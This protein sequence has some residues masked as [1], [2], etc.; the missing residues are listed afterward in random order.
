MKHHR[1][2]KRNPK[3]QKELEQLQREQERR[4]SQIR[5]VNRH[6]L[7]Q[8]ALELMKKANEEPIPESLHL[9]AL[10]DWSLTNLEPVE[11]WQKV[12]PKQMKRARYEMLEQKIVELMWE[13]E[14][15]EAM[16][17]LLMGPKAERSPDPEEGGGLKQRLKGVDDP[18][19]AGWLILLEIESW[20]TTNLTDNLNPNLGLT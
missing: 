1:K 19:E 16:E 8:K 18:M 4:Q 15:K 2:E 13:E 14:P 17:Y 9:L 11:N 6:P 3:Q 10:A 5:V 12:K 20:V 7:N